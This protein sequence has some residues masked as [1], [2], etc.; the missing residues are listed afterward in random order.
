MTPTPQ[1]SKKRSLTGLRATGNLHI[2]NYLGAMKPALA[3]SKTYSAIYFIADLHALTNSRDPALLATQTLD[4]L[5]TWLALGL[6]TEEHILFRQSDVPE[7]TELSWFLSCVTNLGLLEK[8]HA[9]KDAVAQGA[10]VNHGLFAYPVLMAADIL[11]YD[12]DVVPVGKDQKQ[13]VEMARD[14][15]GAFNAIYGDVLKLPEPIIQEDVK[16]I[17][18]LDGRKMSKSY[19]NEIPL[20]CEEKALRKK[21]M[22]L[23][24]D[25]TPLEDPK[26]LRGSLVGDLFTLFASAEQFADLEIR[27]AKG[28]MGWG[29]AKEELFVAINEHVTPFRA[30]YNELRSDEAHL[31]LVLRRGAEK[32]RAIASPTM[33]RVRYAVGIR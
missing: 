12:A 22:S 18:G 16:V 33:S 14:M 15:A 32:A 26:T 10:D 29:H 19:G 21:L 6:D 28:G 25:S 23:K 9:F 30:R 20:L 4:H 3:F 8:S 13:H 5:A 11:L 24:T 7:H 27:L 17:P 2:G 31:R 1:T